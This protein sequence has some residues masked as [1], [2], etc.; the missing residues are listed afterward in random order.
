D[1]IDE[2][3]LK[4]LYTKELPSKASKAAQMIMPSVVMVR[5]FKNDS[6]EKKKK[7]A[8]KDNVEDGSLGTGVIVMEDGT[9]LT[10][11]HVIAGSD[12]VEVIFYDG[13]KANAKVVAVHPHN[14]L[15]ILKPEKL[16]DDLLPATLG[17][18][19]Q[20]KYGD[21]VVAVGFPF[22]IGPS[23]SAGVVSGL[24]REFRSPDGKRSLRG[25][26]QFDAA[27]N[28][29]SSGGP[30]VNQRGEVVGIVTAILNPEKSRTF[31]GIGFA[32]TMESAGSAMG[33]PRF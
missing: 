8:K 27:A 5:A 22:G 23:V 10:N 29:G 30:L 1:I 25:L 2:A 21:D 17:S 28:P 26:I 3:V 33:L 11:Y 4:T 6:D 20:L 13:T 18:S 12:R 9:I 7:D 19:A 15:A 14:D 16:P 24:D 32:T 31:I